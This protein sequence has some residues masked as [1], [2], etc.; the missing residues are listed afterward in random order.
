VGWLSV[1]TT[2][3]HQKPKVGRSILLMAAVSDHLPLEYQP[4]TSK[5]LKVYRLLERL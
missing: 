3:R 5:I 2:D 1:G 4:T